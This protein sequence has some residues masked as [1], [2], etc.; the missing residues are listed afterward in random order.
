MSADGVEGTLLGTLVMPYCSGMGNLIFA[1]LVGI[2]GAPGAEVVINSLV[3]NVTNLLLLIGLPAIFFGLNLLPSGKPKK[4]KGAPQNPQGIRLSLLLT[5]T[6]ALFF[7]GIT[8]A[9]SQDGRIDFNDGLVLIALFLFWQTFHFF[10][11]L[12]TNARQN[13]RFSWMLCVNLLLLGAGAYGIYLSTDWLVEWIS[14]VDSGWGR[15]GKL[16]WLSGW[17]MVLP[18]ALLAFYYAW[19]GKPEVVYTSQVGDGHICIPLCIGICA[20][21]Q[22]IKTPPFFQTGVQLLLGATVFHLLM[23]T[24]TGRLPRFGGWLLV[25]AYLLFLYQGLIP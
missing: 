22:P 23:V 16:G 1:F 6:A 21:Y 11:V 2:K 8:W 20:L 17:I 13:R 25:G 4:R 14:R 12:K 19:R 18:N 15:A 24:L 5:L 10:E 9:L 3:N 7:T